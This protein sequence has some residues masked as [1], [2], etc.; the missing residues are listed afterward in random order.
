M[1][2]VQMGFLSD[3]LEW[4]YN[5]IL[6]PAFEL[7]NKL[8]NTILGYLFQYV[9]SPILDSVLKIVLD[10]VK[11][12]IWEF[13]SMLLYRLEVGILII[14]DCMQKVFNIYIG[15][16]PVT[17]TKP[18]GEE[19]EGSLL[20]ILLQHP[21]IIQI[22]L[23]I[24]MAGFV[25]CFL[26]AIF[27]TVKAAGNMEVREDKSVAHVMRTTA[28]AMVKFVTVPVM[29]IFLIL[30]A[31]TILV[32]LN[33][34][35][36]GK[37]GETF[38]LARTVF[39]ISAL[40]AV[41]TKKHSDGKDYNSSTGNL[42]ALDDKYHGV[43][44]HEP[45]QFKEEKN[46]SFQLFGFKKTGNTQDK[47]E[48][49]ADY[50]RNLDKV[51]SILDIKK[52]DFLT[53]ILMAILF[54][55][56]LLIGDLYCIERIFGV[57]VLLFIEPFFIATMPLDDGKRFEKWQELFIGKLFSAY[58]MVVGMNMYLM[59]M[60]TM[61][62]GDIAFLDVRKGPEIRVLDYVVKLIFMIGA[63]FALWITASLVTSI[64]SP[65][66]AQQEQQTMAKPYQE[67]KKKE[68]KMKEMAVKAAMAVATVATGGAAA[69]AA[70]AG[71][72]AAG[73]ASAA[74][75]SA[76]AAGSAAASGAAAAGSAA[77]GSAAAGGAAAGSAAGGAA[78]G[79]AAGGSAAGGA[80]GSGAASGGTSA[81]SQAGGAGS[82]QFGTPK[83]GTAKG[84]TAKGGSGKPGQTA[85][86]AFDEAKKQRGGGDKDEDPKKFGAKGGS[87]SD[88]GQK[89]PDGGGSDSDDGDDGFGDDFGLSDL[90]GGDDFGGDFGGD[91]GD[92]FGDPFGGDMLGDMDA[93][94]DAGVGS[95]QFTGK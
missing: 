64:L 7:I 25:F 12:L 55:L 29:A 68:K 53:G 38:S 14:L 72:V 81:A 10:F 36:T 74:A 56:I 83:G 11:D 87:S 27:A 18:N 23:L 52:I 54:I 90:F 49:V 48:K 31:D 24:L 46:N 35:F 91:F 89:F 44:F 21:R 79:G 34:A 58:G 6:N 59:I 62:N 50:Y 47:K 15:L 1:V 16:S 4:I 20:L 94:S 84:G 86:K 78:A 67:F 26:C 63:G 76:A 17:Y 40:D 22:L 61:F 43:F 77:A 95:G 37:D 75:S 80:A 3:A 33:N 85:K 39:T 60:T 57:L 51:T 82:H 9:L 88:P 5:K 32:S 45:E 92:D 2:I 93:F 71:S 73:A 65:Q 41:D 8:M 13:V 66:V 42:C 30:L 28:R 70:A 69:P 19:I